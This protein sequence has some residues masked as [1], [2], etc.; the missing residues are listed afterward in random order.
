MSAKGAT[1]ALA[2]LIGGFGLAAKDAVARAPDQRQA[3]PAARP[4][5]APAPGAA[6]AEAARP[7]NPTARASAQRSQNRAIRVAARSPSAPGARNGRRGQAGGAWSAGISCVPYA[8]QATGMD[9]SGNGRDWWHNAAGVY[10]RNNR[11]EVGSIMAFP[12]SG[13]MR[14]GHV[15]VVEHVVSSRELLIHHA[16]WGG[17]GIRR[18]SIMRGVSVIDASPGND[19]TQ[20]RV[21]VGHSA[22]NFGRVYP[23]YGFIHNRPDAGGGRMMAARGPLRINAAQAA[24][25]GF[26]EVAQAPARRR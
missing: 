25:L 1:I 3:K 24:S 26:E 8:R 19:W 23:V 14:S 6:R 10:A 15:A 4:A 2:L 18:G 11:P 21:Q 5:A 7:A 22:E 13:G 20:V 9:I 16:N 17:P 12:G